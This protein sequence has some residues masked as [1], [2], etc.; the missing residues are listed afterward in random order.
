[1]G[2]STKSVPNKHDTFNNTILL[3]PKIRAVRVPP[4][5]LRDPK[6]DYIFNFNFD[7]KMKILAQNKSA[8]LYS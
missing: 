3:G 8:L 2:F 5:Q 1:M 6:N 7:D 4:V